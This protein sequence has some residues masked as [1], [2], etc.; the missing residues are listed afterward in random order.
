MTIIVPKLFN[1]YA[2]LDRPTWQQWRDRRLRL[3]RF[4]NNPAFWGLPEDQELVRLAGG[5]H[6]SVSAFPYGNTAA[7]GVSSGGSTLA[8]TT[9]NASDLDTGVVTVGIRFLRTG[10]VQEFTN[11]SWSTQNT[12]TEWIAAA[13]E[14]ATIGDDH[15]CK[16]DESLTSNI[17]WSSGWGD[18]TYI[19][20]SATR[21]AS[22]TS[23]GAEKTAN[24]TAYVR[25]T[26]DTSNEVSASFTLSAESIGG[27][28][29]I[30][31]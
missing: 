31:L 26:A 27:M 21:S 7:A 18:N 29:G 10:D 12:N 13:E 2:R 4:V 20:I 17:V 3:L 25:E 6:L 16:M 28:G 30:L 19:A 15:Q 22:L 11:G 23:L 5:P 9:L 24:G 1:M 14:T 8:L